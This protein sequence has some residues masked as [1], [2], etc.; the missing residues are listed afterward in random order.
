[1]KKFI[2]A[3]LSLSLCLCLTL[4]VIPSAGALTLTRP[5]PSLNTTIVSDDHYLDFYAIDQNGILWH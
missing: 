5:E 3:A 1:M 2:R 4:G